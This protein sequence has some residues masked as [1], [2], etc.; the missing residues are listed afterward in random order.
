MNIDKR[1]INTR[2]RSEIAEH[3]RFC[4]ER[5]SN[6]RRLR[7]EGK[8][9]AEART[10]LYAHVTYFHPGDAG[11]Y[12]T[13]RQPADPRD[14]HLALGIIRGRPYKAIENRCHT[15]PDAETVAR[16]LVG[17]A[18]WYEA[19]VGKWARW[20]ESPDAP[21]A[22]ALVPA[23]TAWLEGAPFVEAI[24]TASAVPAAEAAVAA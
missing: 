4:R 24:S 15:P 7:A 5:R 3:V 21:Q 22:K 9:D 11:E 2:L 12:V 20:Q 17:A 13:H 6:Y 8:T 18:R 10:A 23:V 1:S 19:P 16:A 14:M